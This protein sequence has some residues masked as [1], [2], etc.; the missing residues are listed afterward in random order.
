MLKVSMKLN[1]A[2]ENLENLEI[3]M[4]AKRRAASAAAKAALGYMR[5]HAP[6]RTGRV[7]AS[8]KPSSQRKNPKKTPK[9]FRINRESLR[10]FLE[11]DALEMRRN[12]P[13]YYA[14]YPEYGFYHVR[15]GR[16]HPGR[17]DRFGAAKAA[18][19]VI[20]VVLIEEIKKDLA[21]KHAAGET[22]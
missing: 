9:G 6:L 16:Y 20:R 11:N 5:T 2:F 12:G 3:S 4:R 18:A 22:Q 14:Q 7:R 15:Q 13:H 17:D 1:P 10:I 8:W 21:A 19:G